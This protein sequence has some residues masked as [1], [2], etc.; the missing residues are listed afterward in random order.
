[1]EMRRREI[2]CDNNAVN[3]IRHDIASF[4]YPTRDDSTCG[5]GKHKLEEEHGDLLIRKRAEPVIQANEVIPISE[6]ET[7]ANRPIDQT[8]NN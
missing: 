1:M 2:T 5:G 4:R 7:K 3:K 8:S 6:R